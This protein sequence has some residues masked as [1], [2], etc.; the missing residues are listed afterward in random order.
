MLHETGKSDVNL[1]SCEYLAFPPKIYI[2][3][4]VHIGVSRLRTWSKWD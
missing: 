4:F 2:V 1:M 3:D